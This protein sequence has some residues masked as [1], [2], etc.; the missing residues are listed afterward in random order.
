M[1]ESQKRM[2]RIKRFSQIGKTICSIFMVLNTLVII[3]LIAMLYYKANTTILEDI[4]S[5]L[6]RVPLSYAD[7]VLCI[8]QYTLVMKGVYHLRR[9]FSIYI[10]ED[11][12]VL[13]SIVQIRRIAFVF[14]TVA[15]LKIVQYMTI[16]ALH[17]N[18]IIDWSKL[19]ELS[20]FGC[21]ILF[22]SWIMETGH[23]LQE[24]NKLTI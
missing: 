18:V 13:A 10:G 8:V 20:M 7:I 15:I 19:F 1:L 12:F 9:L 5:L 2:Q 21:L 3:T 22:I 24:E 6:K 4:T 23:I 11:I 17:S 14:F 16:I